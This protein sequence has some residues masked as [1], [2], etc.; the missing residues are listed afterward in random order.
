MLLMQGTVLVELEPQVPVMATQGAHI[1]QFRCSRRLEA[2]TFVEHVLWIG[3][4]KEMFAQGVAMTVVAH[5]KC[6][7]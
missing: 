7:S 2:L 6:R 3:R 4:R 5:C 1:G